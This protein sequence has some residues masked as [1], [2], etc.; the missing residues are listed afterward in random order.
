M[1]H[2]FLNR[3]LSGAMLLASIAAA[4]AASITASVITSGGGTSRAGCRALEG[5][6][7]EPAV[8]SMTGGAFTLV[9]GYWAGPG[10]QHRDL[11]FQ[12]GFQ[13]CDP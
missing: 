2:R 5:S 4:S 1:I 12:Q 13:G 8:G 6:F 7:G 10:S 3:C 9:S 11:I